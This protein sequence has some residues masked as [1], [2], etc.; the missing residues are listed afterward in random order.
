MRTTTEQ[1]I[2]RR[3]FLKGAGL[4]AV[5]L[6]AT[7]ALAACS[8]QETKGTDSGSSTGGAVSNSDLALSPA[9]ANYPWPANPPEIADADVEAEIDCDVVVVGLGVA[10]C[11]AF[12]SAAEAGAK[13]VG[14]E[15]AAMPQQRSSQYAYL[16]GPHS[17]AWGLQTF[18]DQELME[19]IEAEVK[20]QNYMVKQDIWVRWAR[21]SAQAIEWYCNGVPGFNFEPSVMSMEMPGEGAEGAEGAEAEPA[22]PGIGGGPPADP[23]TDYSE[24]R[25]AYNIT[26]FF[27]DHQAMLDGQVTTAEGLGAEAYFGH[28]AEKLIVE[29]GRVVGA[30][31]R[32]ANTDK[33]V[34]ANAAKGVIMACGDYFSNTD[35]VRFFRPDL[36]ENGNGNPWPNMDVEGNFTNTGDGYKLG[37]W[38]GA[39]IQQHHAPMT[40]IMGG[41]GGV[42]ETHGTS[43]GVMGAAPYLRLNWHGERFMNED[44]SNVNDEYQVDIQPRRQYLM[45]F[46]GKFAEYPELAGLM[47]ASQESI[48]AAI[49]AGKCFK[50]ETVDELLDN[51]KGL[52]GAAGYDAAGKAAALASIARY[53]ELV[54][55]G[56]DED[57]NKLP[58]YLKPLETGPFY[59]QLTGTAL[60]LVVIGGGLESDKE[61]HVLDTERTIIPGLYA[62][63]N[64]QG[65]RFAIKYPFKLG[66]ASHCMAMF[67]GYVAGQNAAAGV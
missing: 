20:E 59:A 60:C 16:N 21:E 3:D 45:F 32:N 37:Y 42:N 62:A 12:R 31:A 6:A 58:K 8:P 10:G 41:T 51:I 25:N 24:D 4:G 7:G 1:G 29:G 67:Y 55:K 11:A 56:Y 35:M 30:Y 14:F 40:H 34:K 50:G 36:I 54:A 66:G 5:G 48:D 64:I 53:N 47:P 43:M 57:F 15:K 46:D 9:G 22:A 65:S 44:I 13:V 61:A 52:D 28:F 2:D 23:T 39:S 18:S 63:G 27:S 17:E 19:I 38:A 49:E 33:Y 26:L